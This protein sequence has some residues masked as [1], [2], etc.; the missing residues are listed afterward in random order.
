MWGRFIEVN[1]IRQESTRSI[2]PN[3]KSKAFHWDGY[4]Y[5]A[6]NVDISKGIWAKSL[7]ML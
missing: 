5:K 1:T 2:T 3:G 7:T 4:D 6:S